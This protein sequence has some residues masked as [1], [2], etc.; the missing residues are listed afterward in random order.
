MTFKHTI[1]LL[2]REKERL[3]QERDIYGQ[4]KTPKGWCPSFTYEKRKVYADQA[5]RRIEEI[6][7]VLA[8]IENQ[9]S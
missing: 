5:S 6:D 4:E 3:E 8:L 7:A 9:K 2:E 1:Q